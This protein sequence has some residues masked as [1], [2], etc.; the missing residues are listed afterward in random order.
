MVSRDNSQSGNTSQEE[1]IIIGCHKSGARKSSD[2]GGHFD[3]K[4]SPDKGEKFYCQ[5]KTHLV[6]MPFDIQMA[7][8]RHVLT[9]HRCRIIIVIILICL[10]HS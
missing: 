4:Q 8:T 9:V 7:L 3:I 2:I 6:L 1:V 10:R 5:N